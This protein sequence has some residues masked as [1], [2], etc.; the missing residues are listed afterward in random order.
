MVPATTSDRAIEHHVCALT[1]G[2][3]RLLTVGL[4]EGDV[5]RSRAVPGREFGAA[6]GDAMHGALNVFC[7]IVSG[8]SRTSQH[9]VAIRA[10]AIPLPGPKRCRKWPEPAWSHL[11]PPSARTVRFGGALRAART[12]EARETRPQLAAQLDGGRE[13]KRPDCRSSS[14]LSARCGNRSMFVSYG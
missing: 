10:F 9:Q 14:P 7:R 8:W 11:S 5:G 1:G 2:P 13:P 4:L 6:C 3:Q 12:N